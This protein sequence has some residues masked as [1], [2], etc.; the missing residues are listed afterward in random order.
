MSYDHS[1]VSPG[2]Y[3]R[4][5][6]LQP[7]VTNVVV[8]AWSKHRLTSQVYNLAITRAGAGC[9]RRRQT[10]RAAVER[11]TAITFDPLVGW[12][13]VTDVGESVESLTLTASPAQTGAS[14]VVEPP[15]ADAALEGYKS[16]SPARACGSR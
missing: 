8:T 14:V 4:Q 16:R 7:G 13:W 1:D 2:V 5:V 11:G 15:D 10:E 3:G 6:S 9:G 12:Y